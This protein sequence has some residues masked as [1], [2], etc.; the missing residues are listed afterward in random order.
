MVVMSK[1][2]EDLGGVTGAPCMRRGVGAPKWLRFCEDE[3]VAVA[4]E[5]SFL[6]VS[7]AAPPKENCL[8]AFHI[9]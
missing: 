1:E 9:L 3:F 7:S 4:M 2:C 6:F 5:S 8:R